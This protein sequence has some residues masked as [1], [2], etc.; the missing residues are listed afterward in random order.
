MGAPRRAAVGGRW[1]LT[2]AEFLRPEPQPWGSSRCTSP[3]LPE[4]WGALGR[5]LGQL[6]WTR[7]CGAL[8]LKLAMCPDL[9]VALVHIPSLV[10]VQLSETEL[11]A[12]G[13]GSEER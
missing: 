13:F 2:W 5:P 11:M 6:F 10:I 1:R 8:S 3:W 4:D 12:G 9:P 7:L